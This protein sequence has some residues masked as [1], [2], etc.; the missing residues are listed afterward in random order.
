MLRPDART[1]CIGR[2]AMARK[3]AIIPTVLRVAPVWLSGYA[4]LVLLIAI[5]VNLAAQLSRNTFALTLPSMEKSL[6][7]SHTQEGSLITA[8]S[9]V[10]MIGSLAFGMLAPRYG[11]RYMVGFGAIGGGIAMVFLG[12]STSF[13]FALVMSGVIGLASG[14]MITPVMGLLVVWFDSRNRGAAAGLAA[15]GGGVSFIV[16]G[17][18]VPWL[19]GRDPDDG[20]RDAWYSLAVIVI[21]IGI[22]SLVFLRDR[23]REPAPAAKIREAW[24]T[25][26]FRSPLV[27]L[28]SFLAFCSGWST[29]LYTTFFGVYLDDQGIGQAVSGRLWMLLG[30]LAIVSGV[31]WGGVSDRLGRRPGFL[32]SFVTYGVGC[33]LFWLWPV[34]AGFIVSVILVGLSFRAAFTICAAASGD[35]V[36]PRVAA[37]AFGLMGLGAGLGHSIGPYIGGLI[38]DET[39][40]L[41]LIF[42][43]AMAGN[44]VAIFASALLGRPRRVA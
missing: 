37:A 12:S 13:L 10:L 18:L 16:I 15:A 2:W 29:G 4:G 8:A 30:L 22:I 14:A 7:L 28:V 19:T 26:A 24:P 39:G 42:A 25:S 1:G 33:M 38:A 17:A 40:D 23:P 9:V 5:L 41:G 21:A 34:L 31:F 20:W 43:L 27:W 3:V 6:G 32:L 35:Y 44:A 11:T 36:S